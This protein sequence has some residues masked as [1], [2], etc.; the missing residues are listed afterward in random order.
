MGSLAGAASMCDRL[1][2]IVAA[3]DVVGRD[4]SDDPDDESV[5]P[6]HMV[7][8]RAVP[9][10]IVGELQRSPQSA[11]RFRVAGFQASALAVEDLDRGRF[12]AWA[13]VGMRLVDAEMDAQLL[14]AAQG[15][16]LRHR[17]RN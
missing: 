12:E 17:P 4:W 8:N 3:E 11:A 9:W 7:L 10:L 13:E 5:L 16:P 1:A 14:Q 2:G 6:E 15:W